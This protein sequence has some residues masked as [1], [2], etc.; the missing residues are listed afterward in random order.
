MREAIE[1]IEIYFEQVIVHF[2]CFVQLLQFLNLPNSNCYS[3]VY[4]W[5]MTKNFPLLHIPFTKS[6]P[7]FNNSSSSLAQDRHFTAPTKGFTIKKITYF[8]E[9]VI[10][11]KN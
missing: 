1:R 8:R 10:K 7:L 4:H 2:I 11:R 9:G 5:Q 3:V 6:K